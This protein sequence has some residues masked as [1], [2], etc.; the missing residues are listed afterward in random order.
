MIE[1][2]CSDWECIVVLDGPRLVAGPP[3]D[4]RIVIVEHARSRQGPGAARNTGM[5]AARGTFLAFLDDDDRLEATRLE[6]ALEG[7]GE[8]NV[9]LCGLAHLEGEHQVPSKMSPLHQDAVLGQIHLGQ[10]LVRRDHAVQF[11]PWLRVGEDVEWWIRMA[12]RG[13]FA[14]TDEPGYLL[15]KHAGERAGVDPD[16][17]LACRRAILAVHRALL[18]QNRRARAHHEARVAAA[19]LLARRRGLASYWAVRAF[20]TRPTRLAVRIIAK[21]FVSV[22][23]NDTRTGGGRD[24]D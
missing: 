5:A 6:V 18:G 11:T 13:P 14:A 15:R 12:D 7:I 2:T 1:Q 4:E 16:V 23:Q 17:R 21:A 3:E 20:V 9:H 8:R 24:D 10:A 19:A 22:F